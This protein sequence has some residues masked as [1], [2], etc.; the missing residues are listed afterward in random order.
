MVLAPKSSDDVLDYT[1]DASLI[2]TDT[3]DTIASASLL[4]SDSDPGYPL[5]VVWS[6]VQGTQVVLMLASGVPLS[7]PIL[8]LEMITAQQRRFAQV[9]R[10]RITNASA[11]TAAP[12][13]GTVLTVNGVDITVGANE[14]TLT[15]GNGEIATAPLLN[16]LDSE[17][18]LPVSRA[19]DGVQTLYRVAGSSLST[20]GVGIRSLSVTQGDVVAGEPSNVTLSSELTDGSEID[21]GTFKAPPGASGLNAYQ[22]AQSAGFTGTEAE[23][24]LSLVGADG[25]S[26]YQVAVT[27]GYVGTQ[28]EWVASLKGATGDAGATGKTGQDGAQGVGIKEITLTQAPVTVGEQSTVTFTTTL[29]DGTETTPQAFDI[30]A[31]AA[32]TAGETGPAGSDATVTS[33][34]ITTALGYS[35]ADP[36]KFLGLSPVKVA[37]LQTITAPS[38]SAFDATYAMQVS[39]G[40]NVLQ[41]GCLDSYGTR[42]FGIK[43]TNGTVG[44]RLKDQFNN[45]A[46]ISAHTSAD[47]SGE[48]YSGWLGIDCSYGNGGLRVIDKDSTG[49]YWQFIADNVSAGQK[50][51]QI[52]AGTSDGT[53]WQKALV[54]FNPTTNTAEFLNEPVVT[55]TYTF[56]TLPTSPED[57]QRAIVTDK[58]IG[59]GAQGVVA[60]W[61]P[62]TKTWTGLSGETL[63]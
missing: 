58:A 7:N 33:A 28:A 27:N 63:V 1:I 31:G 23:W 6:Q 3:S 11:A 15:P 32:G 59:S 37:D 56:A 17:D 16:S 30:P 40:S 55:T 10:A 12:A 62:N 57:W 9:L 21:A 43:S 38:D 29:S 8:V 44:I 47:G 41:V 60:M 35:P 49:F 45:A 52:M 24:L 36:S 4:V 20:A 54:S 19:V 34:N 39:D 13:S 18:F 42:W 46:N 2:L 22:V 53:A 51:W 61:N 50:P 26:A 25:A 5:T 14:V 48:I